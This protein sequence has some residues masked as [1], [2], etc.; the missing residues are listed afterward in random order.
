MPSYLPDEPPSVLLSER[1][2]IQGFLLS[3]IVYGAIIVLSILCLQQL[4][5]R[6]SMSSARRFI[7]ITFVVL[8]LSDSTLCA[9]CAAASVQRSWIDNREA[10]GGP[11]AVATGTLKSPFNAASAAG[12]AIATW[13]TDAMMVSALPGD[14]L[15]GV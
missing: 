8:I 6:H 5:H 12:Y 1:S 7:F 9:V 2:L 15:G 14:E 11:A 10:P 3:E 4:W 13:F